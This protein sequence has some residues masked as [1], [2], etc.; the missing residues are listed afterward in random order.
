ML[1][2]NLIY[3]IQYFIDFLV[4]LLFVLSLLHFQFPKPISI[5]CT[6][7]SSIH[8]FLH[9]C[10]ILRPL[11]HHCHHFFILSLLS[12][13]FVSQFLVSNLN[14]QLVRLVRILIQLKSILYFKILLPWFL[15]ILNL[16]ITYKHFY[17]W[18]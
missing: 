11:L 18:L 6:L 12:R 10:F 17:S 14:G 2:L 5:C 13:F 1:S 4:I 15:V 8:L 3:Y 16:L 9:F 7:N